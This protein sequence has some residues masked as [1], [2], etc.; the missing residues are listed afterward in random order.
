MPRN[1]YFQFKQFRI[2]QEQSAMKV[3][4]DGVL[5]G[6]WVNASEAKRILGVVPGIIVFPNKS[7]RQNLLY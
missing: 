6:A 2:I 3:G 5:I 4:M 7:E 1:N